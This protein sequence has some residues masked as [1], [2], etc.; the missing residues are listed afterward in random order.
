MGEAAKCYRS[1]TARLNDIGPDRVDFQ[2]SSK[3]AARYM[4][5]PPA[6]RM[7]GLRNIAKYLAGRSRRIAHFKWQ[8]T[9]TVVS[10]YTVRTGPGV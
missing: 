10:G 4:A 2:Y 3:E 8:P 5:V 7:N 1:V 9:P 6:L